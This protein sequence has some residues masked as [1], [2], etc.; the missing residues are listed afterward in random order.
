MRGASSA[1]QDLPDIIIEPLV[2]FV[3][4]NQFKPIYIFIEP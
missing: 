1:F 3:A 2:I 4:T